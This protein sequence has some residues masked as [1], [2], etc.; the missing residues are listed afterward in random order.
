[1]LYGGLVLTRAFDPEG[2]AP[3]DVV[4]IPVPTTL[5]CVLV[6]PHQRLETRRARTVLPAHVPLP[7]AVQQTANAAALV[8]GCYQQDLSLVGRALR[9]VLVEPHRKVLVPGFDAVQ[10]AAM[11]AGALG[12]SL[13]GAGPTAFAWCA[14]DDVARIVRTAMTGA[15]ADAGF[16]ADA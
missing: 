11:E 8:A 15:F 1:M 4:C 12:C 3:P 5:R 7:D 9:D 6:R 2:V 10:A 16:D 14:G 13:S